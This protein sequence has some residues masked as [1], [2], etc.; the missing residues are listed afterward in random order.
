MLFSVYG[1]SEI[2]VLERTLSQDRERLGY[3][4]C[5]QRKLIMLRPAKILTFEPAYSYLQWKE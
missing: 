4:Q 5:A 1:F 2:Q 3:I